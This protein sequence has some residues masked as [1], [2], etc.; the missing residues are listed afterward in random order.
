MLMEKWPVSRR[1]ETGRIENAFLPSLFPGLD[2][3]SVSVGSNCGQGKAVSV[4]E[5]VFV[6]S[7]FESKEIHFSV[8]VNLDLGHDSADGCYSPQSLL[9]A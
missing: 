6:C 1:H 2:S 5:K 7:F 9:E 8:A 3:L 4:R